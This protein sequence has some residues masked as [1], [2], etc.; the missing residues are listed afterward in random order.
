MTTLSEIYLKQSR[1][2]LDQEREYAEFYAQHLPEFPQADRAEM[3]WSISRIPWITF[4]YDRA[5]MR[6]VEEFLL[7]QGWRM[8]YQKTEAEVGPNEDPR[9]CW[10][11]RIPDRETYPCH[12]TF[13]VSFSDRHPGAVCQRLQIGIA[14]NER[15]VYDFVCNHD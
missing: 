15:P 10:E 3:G 5:L 7:A 6:A 2:V 12:A 1:H 4:P 13:I 11:K 14:T 8:S 9:Q